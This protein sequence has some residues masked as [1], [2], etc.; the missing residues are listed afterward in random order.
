MMCVVLEW[1]LLGVKIYLSHAHQ[2]EI[3]E[4][5]RDFFENFWHGRQSAIVCTKKSFI[6][7]G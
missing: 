5:L 4:P 7:K 1:D 6:P 2:T 3:L